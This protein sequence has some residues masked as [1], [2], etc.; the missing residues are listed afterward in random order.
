MIAMIEETYSLAAMIVIP[1]AVTTG[2][3]YRTRT[4]GPRKIMKLS[5]TAAAV[6]TVLYIIGSVI[7]EGLSPYFGVGMMLVFPLY[8]MY[9]LALA[10]I[11]SLALRYTNR[12]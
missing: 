3:S 4:T 2:M 5:L 10:S 8:V 1:L 12:K 6:S 9:C 7:V 11:Y